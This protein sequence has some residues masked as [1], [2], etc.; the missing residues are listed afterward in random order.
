MI[1]RNTVTS[2]QGSLAL[3]ASMNRADVIGFEINRQ[4]TTVR[5]T[6]TSTARQLAEQAL[7][8]ELH[9]QAPSENFF[10]MISGLAPRPTVVLGP[11]DLE[12]LLGGPTVST[13]YAAVENF[14]NSSQTD[15]PSPQ[16]TYVNDQLSGIVLPPQPY[17][18]PAVQLAPVL[19][20]QDVL[21]IEKAAQ[22]IVR[23]T[24]RYSKILWTSMTPEESAIL[25]DGYTIGVPPG[26]LSDASQMIPLLNCLQNTI[27]GTFGNSLIMPFNIP[28]DLADEMNINPAELQQSLL[29]YQQE[30]F[31]SPHSTIGLPTRGVLGEAVLGSC[32]SAEK[33]DLTRFWN[34]QDAPG[35]QAPGIGMV[36]LPTT[37]PPLTTGVTA[38]NSLTNLPPLIN[39]LITAP[40]PNTG[41]LQAMGQQAASQQD[42]SPN[43]TGQQQ[44]ASLMQNGQTQERGP[45]RCVK[46]LADSDNY[47]HVHNEGPGKLCSS[48][49][50]R[51]LVRR[52]GPRSQSGRWHT[53]GNPRQTCWR[54]AFQARRRNGRQLWNDQ[55]RH[56]NRQRH[57]NVKDW[58]R[59]WQRLWNY[60]PRRRHRD[61]HSWQW[62]WNAQPR[63]CDKPYQRDR[64]ERCCGWRRWGIYSQLYSDR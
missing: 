34:W 20:Y 63:Q 57:G 55:A 47:S 15:I 53:A 16:E 54:D 36:Q 6:L 3:P 39:N 51:R 12:P 59:N 37:T 42:F 5:Y 41:L 45:F 17:P 8:Q 10:Q 48:A 28:Q 58:H 52:Q 50:K 44:L 61:Q 30:A 18:V 4:F 60:H 38:P 43:F 29:A 33:I 2:L 62:F 23:N 24:T 7:S 46:G 64:S 9:G 22:H 25:L 32:S 14:N 27:L 35:D 49:C 11:G 21:E 31:V 19:R 56:W 26:G 1:A 40:Q 13:F